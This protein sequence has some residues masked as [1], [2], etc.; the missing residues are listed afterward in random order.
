MKSRIL[1]LKGAG[2]SISEIA[3]LS[4]Y[5]IT[6]ICTVLYSQNNEDKSRDR[7][8]KLKRQIA[9]LVKVLHARTKQGDKVCLSCYIKKISY[10]IDQ[11]FNVK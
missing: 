2:H 9:G 7:P 8:E 4:G 1:E 3:Q 5:T 11:M 6:E 10:F